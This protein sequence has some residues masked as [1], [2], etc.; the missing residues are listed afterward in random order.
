MSSGIVFLQ[1]VVQAIQATRV[2]LQ[3]DCDSSAAVGDL[4]FQDDT[5]PDFV[6]VCVNNTEVRPTIGVVIQKLTTTRVEVLVLGIYEGFTGLGIGD[7]LF[8][9]AT[10][11]V[12]DTAP[13]T[14][15]YWQ[16]LGV[17]VSSTSAFFMPNS[18]RVL[19]I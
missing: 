17:A 1:P 11:T 14:P 3:F 6:N 2:V 7:K 16:T 15:G 13:A 8:L 12:T 5:T 10:G 18:T 4:V 9:S 19:K